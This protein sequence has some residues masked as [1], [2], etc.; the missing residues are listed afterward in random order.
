MKNISKQ[1]RHIDGNMYIQN[2]LLTF[3]LHEE[4]H[5]LTEK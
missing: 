3:H 2:L 1:R 4:E 5:E